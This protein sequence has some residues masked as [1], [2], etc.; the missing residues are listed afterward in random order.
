MTLSF[1]N[2][3]WYL[4]LAA[5]LPL[6]I[7]LMARRR[8][9]ER[10]FSSIVLLRELL[11]LQTRRS[12]PR[13]WLLLLLRT[14]ACACLAAA[15]LLPS[16]GRGSAE[17][18][19]ALVIVLDNTASMAASDGQ[20]Q[21][22]NRA[23]AVAAQ[24]V[25]ALAPG[26]RVNI[27]TL[28][29]VPR[30]LFE[31]PVAA[32]APLLRELARTQSCPATCADTAAALRLAVEQLQGLPEG[33]PGELLVISDFQQ[34]QWQ[35]PYGDILPEGL[36]CRLVS[37]AQAEE[38]EN[39]AICSLS[40]QPARPL[41]GQEISLA[42]RVRRFGGSG[43]HNLTVS[44]A[45]GELRLA[46]PCRIPDSGEATLSFRLTAPASP[47]D[48]LLEAQIDADRFPADDRR[49]LAVSI[50]D[51]LD[52]QA[53][54]ADPAHLGFLLRALENIPFLRTLTVPALT[55]AESDVIVWNAPTKEDVPVIRERLLAGATVLLLPD[56]TR[57]S[58]CRPLLTGEE[59]DCPGAMLTDGSHWK[60]SSATPQD[61][62]FRLFAGTDMSSLWNAPIYRRSEGIPCPEKARVL[63]RYEDGQPALL[64]HP[65][66]RGTLLVW[67][68]PVLVRDNR[69]GF[70]PLFLPAL[71]EILRHSRSGGEAAV[72]EAGLD[73]PA[74]ALPRGATPEDLRLCRAD[75]PEQSLPIRPLPGRAGLPAMVQAEEAALPGTYRWYRGDEPLATLAVPFPVAESALRRLPADELP[76]PP[77]DAAESEEGFAASGLHV[78]W[79]W[80]LAAAL[81]FFLLEL[82]LCRRGRGASPDSAP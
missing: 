82:T 6:L 38:V 28:A 25:K 2:P 11:R 52:C 74:I 77:A 65:V 79:P 66:G 1:A 33:M 76:Q 40:L 20:Q 17:G 75:A 24:A 57:D 15:F 45:A 7:H 3:A 37:V 46:Q 5:L 68:M 43:E 81:G 64:R 58:A 31:Q 67:N 21:R 63:L 39:C 70:S 80:L 18:G 36:P 60:L 49:A 54:A 42:V 78:L 8:P 51:K 72:P 41:P 44:L 61:E 4:M 9:R 69:A 62:C 35:L 22:M 23:V 27:I 53:V 29:G 10:R 34:A 14:L 56:A 32:P 12:R 50:A 16:L 73:R 47:G 55:G 59:G 71:A 19:R 26:D 30:P 13:D 48:W